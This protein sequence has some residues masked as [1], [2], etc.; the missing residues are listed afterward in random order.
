M[1]G[2]II[3]AEELF[4]QNRDTVCVIDLVASSDNQ[5]DEII[6]NAEET[7]KVIIEQAKREAQ[8]LIS[9]AMKKADLI[10]EQGYQDG[11][12]KGQDEALRDK[13][14]YSE[15]F[16]KLETELIEHFQKSWDEIEPEMIMLSVEIAKKIVK[17]EIDSNSNVVLVT[18]REALR[19]L[20]DRQ[21]IK[22]WVNP[23]DYQLVISRKDDI[24]SFCDG[25]RSMEI[26][27]N[28]RT[29]KG[30]CLVESK[31]GHLDARIETQ[32]NVVENAMLEAIRDGTHNDLN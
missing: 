9:A 24:K 10:Q 21:D 6:P 11:F 3:K 20:R 7:A 2:N 30:G 31:N 22:I 16:A 15:R 29:D 26:V 23:D 13:K 19:Q 28:R 8:A 12:K 17:H 32:L 25:I 5:D 14:F 18:I 4:R 1:L 27:E